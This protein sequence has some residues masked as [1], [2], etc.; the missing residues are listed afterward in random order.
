MCEH[1]VLECTFVSLSVPWMIGFNIVRI[2][3]VLSGLVRS[4]GDVTTWDMLPHALNILLYG[5]ILDQK[6]FGMIAVFQML[7][8][9]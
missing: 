8:Q 3:H 2:L 4:L 6:H 9:V 5:V 7:L 1:G